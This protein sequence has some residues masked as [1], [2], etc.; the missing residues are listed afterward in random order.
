MRK[1][2]EQ[3]LHLPVLKEHRIGSWRYASGRIRSLEQNLFG[4]AG[5]DRLFAAE[6]LHEIRMLMQEHKYPQ[7]EFDD[8]V[9][10]ERE[11]SYRLLQEVAAEDGYRTVLLLRNDAHNL[12]VI[13]KERLKGEHARGMAQLCDLM[14]YPNLVEPALLHE[15]VAQSNFEFSVP[16]WVMDMIEWADRAY[17]ASYD[18]AAIDR[19]VDYRTHEM[20]AAMA[21]ELGNAWFIDYFV[22]TRDLINLETL[23]RSRLRH[24]SEAGMKESLLPEGELSAEWLLGLL[25]ESEEHV[26]AELKRTRYEAFAPYVTCYGERGKASEFVRDRDQM[27]I[28]HLERGHKVLEGPE[29]A[30][31]FVL[32]REFEIKNLRFVET[33]IRNRLSQERR[34]SLRRELFN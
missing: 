10:E 26:E 19:A 16:R 33:S 1:R 24:V 20:I 6:D 31:S 21:D 13:M 25:E 22:L 32:A 17:T 2:D 30:V 29:V 7:G 12:K 5:L 34:Q 8:A 28:D 4:S 15:A 23:L 3:A 9:R 27:L 14:L 11:A 18:A